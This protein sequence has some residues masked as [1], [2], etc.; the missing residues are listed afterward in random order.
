MVCICAKCFVS[1]DSAKLRAFLA[2]RARLM[3]NF[4]PEI[5]FAFSC[6]LQ[7]F[8]QKITLVQ[9]QTKFFV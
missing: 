9:A 3:L 6:K 4:S 8:T 2:T 7:S 1:S 5:T